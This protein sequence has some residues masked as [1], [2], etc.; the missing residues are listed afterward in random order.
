MALV[1]VEVKLKDVVDAVGKDPVP[2]K[3]VELK[4]GKGAPVDRT[5]V[6]L[7]VGKGAPVD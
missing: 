3:L 7:N 2:V 6:E 5:V 4:V 1:G